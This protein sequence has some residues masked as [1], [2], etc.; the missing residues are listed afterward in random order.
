M[1]LRRLRTHVENENWFAV[2][3]DF[4]IVVVGVFLGP[5][6]QKFAVDRERQISARRLRSLKIAEDT[7]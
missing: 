1:I 7:S 6:V 3:I 4:A 5:Q 2:G